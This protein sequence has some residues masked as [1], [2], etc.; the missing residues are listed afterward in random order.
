MTYTCPACKRTFTSPGFCPYDGTPLGAA[1]DQ[2]TVMSSEM[3]AEQGTLGEPA[4]KP[5]ISKPP[6]KQTQ[7]GVGDGTNQIRAISAS[8][9]NSKAAA[10]TI[11]KEARNEQYDALIGQT[12]D[13]R[14]LVQR[15]IG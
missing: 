10:S 7:P 4:S 14:Y 12:L 8:E 9:G 13:G 3:K 5:P 11:R 15:K 2:P 6:D 1:A